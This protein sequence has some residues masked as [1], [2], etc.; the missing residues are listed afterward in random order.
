MSD[1]QSETR[2]R[3]EVAQFVI[4]SSVEDFDE[5]VGNLQESGVWEIIQSGGLGDLDPRR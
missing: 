1:E 2:E 5:I 3:L 4:S